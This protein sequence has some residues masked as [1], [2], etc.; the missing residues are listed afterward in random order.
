MTQI[1]F[2]ERTGLVPTSEEYQEIEALYMVAGD[3]VDKDMFCKAFKNVS[4]EQKSILCG[5]LKTIKVLKGQYE[6]RV[7]E[8]EDLHNQKSDM[9]DFLIGKAHAYNDSDF[10]REAV[11]LVGD[12]QVVLRTLSMELTLWDEDKDYIKDNIQ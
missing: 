10:R 5:M 8:I 1:E 3:N 7:N 9:A 11:R 12:K 4:S 2:M 6:E